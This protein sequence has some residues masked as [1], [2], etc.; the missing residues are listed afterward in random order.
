[1]AP[2]FPGDCRFPACFWPECGCPGSTDARR[3]AGARTNDEYQSGGGPV[4]V[5][6]HCT[7]CWDC[8]VILREGGPWVP[9]G[10]PSPV[11]AEST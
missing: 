1:M 5:D 10:E 4:T 2:V 7:L 8:A 6:S 9:A 11:P 3:A